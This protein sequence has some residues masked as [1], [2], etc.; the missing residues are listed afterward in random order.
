MFVLKEVFG[1]V[2][3]VSTHPQ[4]GWHLQPPF[5]PK[6]HTNPHSTHPTTYKPPTQ[7]QIKTNQQLV[8]DT[9]PNFQWKDQFRQARSS[10]DSRQTLLY[11][12]DATIRRMLGRKVCVC[13]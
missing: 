13:K 6:V 11:R 7:T 9:D 12:L 3:E 4:P 2:E 10:N 1:L 8:V 5:P